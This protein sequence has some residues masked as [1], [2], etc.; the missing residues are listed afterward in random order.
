MIFHSILYFYINL[1]FLLVARFHFVELLI[2]LLV[3]GVLAFEFG[4]DEFHHADGLHLIHLDGFLH[5][6]FDDGGDI[7]IVEF[8]DFGAED[9]AVGSG[10]HFGFVDQ[11]FLKQF[12]ARAQSGV[13]D[14][15]ILVGRQSGEFDHTTC[16]VGDL[17]R[18]THI[19]DEHLVAFAHERSF[20]HQSAGFR[21]GHEVTDDVGMRDSER[22]AFRQLFAETRD[23]RAVAAQHIA[24]ACGDEACLSSDRTFLNGETEALDIHLGEAFGGAHDVGGV[25]GF[26]G[27]DLDEL[28]HLIFDRGVGDDVGAIDIGMDRFAGILLHERHMFVGSGMED[29]LRAVSPEDIVHTVHH[30]DVADDGEDLNLREML[31]Q[32]EADEMHRRLGTVEEDER[33]HTEAAEL[34]AEFTADGSGSTRD[35]H[36]LVFERLGDLLHIDLYL[37]ASEDI[38]DAHLGKIAELEGSVFHLGECRR[39]DE[40]ADLHLGAVFHEP[41][42]L[43]E[44]LAAF[45]EKHRTD[46]VASAEACERLLRIE[47]EEREA[48][49]THRHL[50]TIFQKTDDIGVADTFLKEALRGRDEM[51]RLFVDKQT[52]LVAVR[53]AH[54]V[55]KEVIDETAHDDEQREGEEG[56]HED[57]D[58]EIVFL[59]QLPVEK[60]DDEKDQ[61]RLQRD[62]QSD[63]SCF[64]ER[65]VADDSFVGVQQQETGQ[66]AGEREDQIFPGDSKKR[67]VMEMADQR[68]SAS[69]GEGSQ[70]EVAK[71]HQPSVEIRYSL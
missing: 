69:R 48:G 3:F 2:D 12:L 31:L 55:M 51:A 1:F 57:G 21:D 40:H 50:L 71:Q 26:V 17:D 10:K 28:L 4:D 45:D 44:Q 7:V 66:V 60:Q 5:E 25:D 62:S 59:Q 33:L 61:S 67:K 11:Q 14:L 15:D 43:T 53:T 37:V 34:A 38:V 23:D 63:T 13:F 20:K 18:F 49:D 35:H 52:A 64:A 56:I 42:F 68:H 54:D 22:A 36:H 24:E 27:R 58:M 8:D 32:F 6:A 39:I 29:D 30:P 19:E 70:D 65:R 47:G 41:V 16:H 9:A 46:A